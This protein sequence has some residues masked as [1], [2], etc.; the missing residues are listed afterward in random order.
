MR[1]KVGIARPLFL[2]GY[3]RDPGFRPEDVAAGTEP[4]L[5]PA[6]AEALVRQAERALGPGVLQGYV[7]VDEA[8]P[9]VRGRIRFAD[10]VARR[11]GLPLPVEWLRQGGMQPSQPV[12]VSYD[13]YRAE[14]AEN[15]ILRTALCRMLAV[16]RLP[17]SPTSTGGSTEPASSPRDPLGRCGGPG[18]SAADTFPLCGWPRSSWTISLRNPARARR[19]S[20]RSPSTRPGSPRTLSRQSWVRR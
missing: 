6:L 16:L 19:L 13:E 18:A 8:L 14:I 5:W 9:L 12:A 11:P 1:P 20:P 2:L 7:S 4:D 3:A 10:Q 17:G 15:R